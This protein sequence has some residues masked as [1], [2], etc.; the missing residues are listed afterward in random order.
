MN[1]AINAKV[2]CVVCGQPCPP[3]QPHRPQRVTCSDTCARVAMRRKA[4]VHHRTDSPRVLQASVE[5]DRREWSKLVN[6]DWQPTDCPRLNGDRGPCPFV[7]CRNHLFTDLNAA[8]NVVI[9][10]RVA[11]IESAPY[12]CAIDLYHSDRE[13]T[14][15][16]VGDVFNVTRERI[17]QIEQGALE[18]LRR[19]L[20]R[21][22][23]RLEDLV[24]IDHPE[25][26]MASVQGGDDSAHGGHTRI[27]LRHCDLADLDTAEC[28]HPGERAAEP[29][30]EKAAHE[31]PLPPSLEPHRAALKAGERVH[32]YVQLSPWQKREMARR[33]KAKSEHDGR[34]GA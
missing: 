31:A 20:A 15:D 8:G 33:R 11:E 32:G 18:K 23:L 24:T 17:R 7:S 21:R 30:P 10:P 2:L 34:E 1:A 19:G 5:A 4:V 27:G 3:K 16:A 26:A 29:E 22:G 13:W 14:L 28:R 12:T 6:V 25:G 9:D